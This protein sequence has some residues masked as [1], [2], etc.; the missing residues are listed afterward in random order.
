MT[1]VQGWIFTIIHAA[2][3]LA[4]VILLSLLMGCLRDDE[5]ATDKK[6]EVTASQ[7]IDMILQNSPTPDQLK[8]GDYLW[9]GRFVRSFTN[10]FQILEQDTYEIVKKEYAEEGTGEDH[11]TYNLFNLKHINADAQGNIIQIKEG[12]C[13]LILSPLLG[14]YPACAIELPIF[15]DGFYTLSDSL[16]S[17]SVKTLMKPFEVRANAVAQTLKFYNLKVEPKL[18]SLPSKM[19]QAGKCLGF[20]NCEVPVQIVDFDIEGTPNGE[21]SSRQHFTITLTKSLPYI[22]SNLETCVSYQAMIDG[23]PALID[24]CSRVLEFNVG[25]N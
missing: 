5:L 24:D 19:V 7:V 8:A 4:L 23:S 11:V 25:T 20:E 13:R 2:G 15:Q 10:P 17:A 21:L 9:V 16:Q 14:W 12:Q 6:Q 3:T 18:I 22:G 1:K